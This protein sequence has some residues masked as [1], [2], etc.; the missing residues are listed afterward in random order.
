MTEQEETAKKEVA[1]WRYICGFQV[2]DSESERWLRAIIKQYEE[3]YVNSIFL[4]PY[5][6]R[7]EADKLLM[8]GKIVH[9]IGATVALTR[10]GMDYFDKKQEAQRRQMKIQQDEWAS[11][12]NKDIYAILDGDVEILP[13]LSGKDICELATHYQFYPKYGNKP[14]WQYLEELMEWCIDRS[15]VSE[16]L[17]ELFLF[18]KES[19]HEEEWK[20]CVFAVLERINSVLSLRELYLDTDEE[21]AFTI[22]HS[23][24]L[25]YRSIFRTAN[26]ETNMVQLDRGKIFEILSTLSTEMKIPKGNFGYSEGDC[27]G[28]LKQ[29]QDQHFIEGAIFIRGG[30]GYNPLM[31]NLEEAYITEKGLKFIEEYG[32]AEIDLTHE[33]VAA[34]T[35]IAD[36]PAS[37]GSLDEDG[38]NREVRNLI[39]SALIH[40]GYVIK[41]QTQQGLGKNGEKAGELDIRIEKDNIPVAIYEGLIHKDKQYL[42]THIEKAT[43]RY[44]QSGCRAVY[45]VEF[46]KNKGFNGF[47]GATMDILDEYQCV[48]VKETDSGLIGVRIAK[49]TFGWQ[50]DRGDF[51][52]IG[53][54]CFSAPTTNS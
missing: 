38:L 49:G 10:S 6:W 44:N 28:V 48:D 50:G 43:N 39:E 3:T 17:K 41:D 14:R 52:Y 24:D 33:L 12:L 23:E 22:G 5:N 46:S 21:L 1:S 47:W 51:Y 9:G 34:C 32:K 31:M 8:S 37:Y 40:F 15:C 7:I 18:S 11:L 29:L 36:N 53:V 26:G 16:I 35:K 13:R 27:R 25:K 19:M 45:I 2:M 54:N 42:L 4:P 30:W 20:F